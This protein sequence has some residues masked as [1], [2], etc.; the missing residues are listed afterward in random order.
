[1]VLVMEED[2]TVKDE[3][4]NS[5]CQQWKEKYTKLKEKH[6]KVEDGR[7]ALRKGIKLLEQE[8]DKLKSEYQ[9]LKKAFEDERARAESEKQDKVLE[10]ATRVTLEHEI[11]TLKSQILL[12]Q[13]NG[14]LAAKGV[15]EEVANLQ[16]RVSEAETEI[17]K[18]KELLQKERKRVDTEKEK[19]EKERKKARDAAEKLNAEKK[20]ASEEKRIADIERVKVEELRHQLESLKC[21]VDEAKSKL[22]LETAKHEQ[23]N[24]KLKAEKENTTKER[25]RADMEKAKAA[26]QGK[27]AEENWKKAM[28][29]RSRADALA[30]QLDKNKHRLEELEK[31]ISNLVSNRKFVDIPV[32]NPPGGLAE[33]AGKVG[34]LTWKSEAGALEACNKLGEWQQ[35]NVREKKQAI[36]EIEKAK[37]QMKAAK[38]YKRKAM[39]EK[40]HVDHLFHELEGN[41]KRLEEVQREIQELVSS[42]K[43]FESSHPASGKSLKDET[44]EIKLLRK[45]LKFEK[46]RVK[47]AKEVAKLE[48]GRN[49]L[50]QQEV[51]RLK[52]EFIPF[53]QRLDLLDNCLF[54][55]FDGINNLEKEGGLDLD[56]E[57]LHL[58][59]SQL[60]LHTQNEHVKPSCITSIATGGSTPLKRNK[61]LNV[62]LPPVSGEMYLSPTTGID[63]NLELLLRGSNRKMLQSS[64][65]NSSSASFSDRPLVGS[66]ERGTFSVTT[67]ANLAHGQ[68]IG[69]TASRLSSDTRKRYDKKLAVG[70]ENSVGSP[71]KS[72]A[73]E[74]GSY[75][76]RKRKR[77]SDAVESIEDLYSAGQKWHQQVLEKLSVL[78][79]MLDGECPKS[80]R[81][82]VL[83]QD[84]MYS[85]LV[86]PDKKKKVSNGQGVAV[87]HLCDRCVLKTSAED[88]DVCE[89]AS[90]AV[91][92]VLQTAPTLKDGIT[93]HFGSKLHELTNAEEVFGHDYMGLVQLDN[94]IDENRFC[95]AIRK[96]ISPLSPV[97][98]NIEFPFNETFETEICTSRSLPDE[99]LCE[100]FSN[101]EQ[102]VVP[103][104]N[105]DVVNL[106]IDS[107]NRNLKDIEASKIL[108]LGMAT[109]G[110]SENLGNNGSYDSDVICV[111]S[112]SSSQINNLIMASTAQKNVELKMPCES[113][114]AA[115]NGYP[116]YCAVSSS[117]NDSSSISTIFSFITDCMSK[118][119]SNSSLKLWMQNILLSLQK[120]DNLSTQERVSGFFSLLLH[121]TSE[122]AN[123]DHGDL[124]CNSLGFIDSF[125]QQM[126]A[127]LNDAD[128]RKMFL[129]SCDLHELVSLIEDF[130]INR[131]ILVYDD[132][133][134]GV[135]LQHDSRAKVVLNDNCIFWSIQPAS[136]DLLFAGGLLLASIFAAVDEIGFI[137]EVSCNILSMRKINSLLLLRLLHVFA[138][139]C[140]SKYF[141]LEGFS[142]KMSVL[143]CFVVFLERQD[144]SGGC[145]SCLPSVAG[146]S[147][148]IS[149][150]SSCPFKDG[151]VS[152]DFIVSILLGKLKEQMEALNSSS[153]QSVILE[154]KKMDGQCHGEAI[155]SNFVPNENLINFID[156]LSLLELVAVSV[157]WDWTFGNIVLPLFRM[158]DCVQEQFFPAIITLLG[159]LGRIGVDANGYENSGVESI[160]QW[161]SAFLSR[162]TFKD[163][164]LL[165]QFASAFA[166]LDLIAKSFEEVVEANFESFATGNQPVAMDAV[167][168][169]FSSLSN[170]QQSSFRSLHSSSKCISTNANQTIA[171]AA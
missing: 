11:S 21:E 46:K 2:V 51:H 93:N 1:M 112:S 170:E 166:L 30:W 161:L 7:N 49:C 40:N 33:L 25:M 163:F 105:F 118:L 117:N 20:K 91:C 110:S 94:P 26:E 151:V 58:K 24:K 43:L 19:V 5:C 63:S 27:L 158:L 130:L 37:N 114:S 135:L 28:D 132:V 119:S 75:K 131:Q 126:R 154:M 138:Y 64:A 95:K 67:S 144:L 22:A 113:R 55:K 83:V 123:G 81:E 134:H 86:R 65:I 35:K 104:C 106:E 125:A 54:H 87:P 15:D 149:A 78:H 13:E 101:A 8:N 53:A 10:S 89:N 9:A 146:T 148:K 4:C 120:A 155:Q 139:L 164:G 76:K 84:N 69:P 3:S 159:Q 34:S 115:F 80:F 129:E 137:C 99:S 60:V 128:T 116:V 82:R 142:L 103:S 153:C 97:L 141:T 100:V 167:R 32:G 38:R 88:S 16:Q 47:H 127:V 96:P 61:R 168:K 73:I 145:I 48:V 147:M 143:K 107:N 124:V 77:V 160:R 98:C 140:S 59:P 45:Q 156:T 85:K 57:H 50:L 165:I 111:S 36:S 92:D 52:Q 74:S 41:R 72:G 171:S 29:E 18:H 133:S 136:T 56:Q 169:W 31:Q 121:Y 12:L 70:A 79:G 90:P 122:I 14:G 23:E 71:I 162:T 108:S 109:K 17:N 68:T 66:Q 150:C 157:S 39:E 44:A 102:N 62:S 42:G 152:V 6:S